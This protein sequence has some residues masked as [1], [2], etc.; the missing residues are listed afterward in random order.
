[1]SRDLRVY[2]ADIADRC[3]RISR[4]VA[5]MDEAVW[6]TDELTQ[7]AVVRNLEVIGEA[8]KRLPMAVREANPTVPWQDIAGLRD[9][10]IHEYEG[11]DFAIVWDVAVNEV[12]LLGEV[13]ASLL[14][15]GPGS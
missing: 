1:M 5:G 14:A 11:V 2:L 15:E 10:L 9:I 4:Y 6:A 3:D 13:V 8:V 7:D 12:P